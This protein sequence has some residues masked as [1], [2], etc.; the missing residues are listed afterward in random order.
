M[1]G[2]GSTADYTENSDA[3]I[4]NGVL[5]YLASEG[6]ATTDYGFKASQ[7]LAKFTEGT[8]IKSIQSGRVFRI[9][10]QPGGLCAVV[11]Y[12]PYIS[13]P[14]EFTTPGV[15]GKNWYNAP[16]GVLIWGGQDS[17][18]TGVSYVPAVWSECVAGRITLE[19]D[20]GSGFSPLTYGTQWNLLTR[21]LGNEIFSQ[22]ISSVPPTVRDLTIGF[23]LAAP[24]VGGETYRMRW[25]DRAMGI[26]PVP[27]LVVAEPSGPGYVINKAM[28]GHVTGGNPGNAISLA[29]L[30][31]C[32]IEVWRQFD[33][34][35]RQ[36]PFAGGT[37][38]RDGIRYIPFWRGTYGQWS[39]LLAPLPAMCRSGFIPQ[40]QMYN[41]KVMYRNPVTGASSCFGPGR[42][43]STGRLRGERNNNYTRS[44][45]QLFY[46][47]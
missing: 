38:Q 26:T 32:V 22:F 45:S 13:T 23:T 15:A 25:V 24:S 4:G 37:R 31:G 5:L 12:D 7:L 17:A 46:G 14:M 27:F 16:S 28:N 10:K 20:T 19:V 35:Q 33:K 3:D 18:Y 34:A 43:R 2:T 6:L 47:D 8:T 41:F 29:P 40:T 39:E 1:Q 44:T 42:I 36:L 21:G 11:E 9:K 30:P